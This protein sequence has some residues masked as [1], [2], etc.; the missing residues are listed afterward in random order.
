[1]KLAC[2][3]KGDVEEQPAAFG[4]LC[5]ETTNGLGFASINEPAAFGRLCVET[6][7]VLV[8]SPMPANP[9]AFGRLCVET[10]L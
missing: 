4:R 7:T 3:E 5:V 2:S 6:C 1:M 9:A 10:R 8:A